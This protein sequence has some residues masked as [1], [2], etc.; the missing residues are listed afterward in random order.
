MTDGLGEN[1]IALTGRV[2][3]RI[4][5]RRSPAGIPIARFTLEHSSM[6]PEAGVARRQTFLIGVRAVGDELCRQLSDLQPGAAVR[7][8][9][10]LARSEQAAEDYRLL[11]CARTVAIL[12]DREQ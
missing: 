11:I 8:F 9:G 5:L 4:Q 3:A 10:F 12:S 1:R 7:V 6:Q 2:S